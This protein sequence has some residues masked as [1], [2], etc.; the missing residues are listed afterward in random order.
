M[1]QMQ[2]QMRSFLWI[3]KGQRKPIYP[4]LRTKA[5]T[6]MVRFSYHSFQTFKKALRT[7]HLAAKAELTAN[8]PEWTW[9]IAD[10]HN[11]QTQRILLK[12][13]ITYQLIIKQTLM[14]AYKSILVICNWIK[15]ISSTTPWLRRWIRDK[16]LIWIKGRRTTRNIAKRSRMVRLLVQIANDRLK[17]RTFFRLMVTRLK[18]I[19]KLLILHRYCIKIQIITVSI[20]KSIINQAVAQWPEVSKT[21]LMAK[22]RSS[23]VTTLQTS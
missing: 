19:P 9:L 7:C 13:E 14:Q 4:R 23:K 17:R 15:R 8:P 20:P 5:I 22:R 3:I 12:Q 10:K 18:T 11:L 16:A 6:T 21:N 2:I 1:K